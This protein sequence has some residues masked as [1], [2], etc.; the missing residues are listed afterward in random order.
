LNLPAKVLVVA[1]SFVG[2]AGIAWSV[3]AYAENSASPPIITGH[4]GLP[5]VPHIIP[6]PNHTGVAYIETNGGIPPESLPS[7]PVL[8]PSQGV[9]INNDF[10]LFPWSVTATSAVAG[11]HVNLSKTPVS[12]TV[13]IAAAAKVAQVPGVI[14]INAILANFSDP[15]S[16]PPSGA[17]T[18]NTHE[19]LN[20]P[21][22]ILD[23][24]IKP[25]CL[26]SAGPN[27]P[28]PTACTTVSNEI[29]AV[30][31]YSG[32]PFFSTATP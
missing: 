2:I 9:L 10:E 25:L 24:T 4:L 23:Y 5:D 6:N 20:I 11:H 1:A 29:I 28:K 22:W 31:A 32:A 27:Q 3:T 26:S 12:K 30:H 18:S 16:V 17:P 13:A 19:F 15:G 7:I 14:S 8:I 21:S